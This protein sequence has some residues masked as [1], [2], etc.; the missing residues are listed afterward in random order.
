MGQSLVG[1]VKKGIISSS[2]SR[3]NEFVLTNIEIV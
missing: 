2:E 1:V 3:T